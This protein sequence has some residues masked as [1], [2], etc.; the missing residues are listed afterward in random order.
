M[1]QEA[2]KKILADIERMAREAVA[3]ARV[4][5]SSSKDVLTEHQRA[6]VRQ[7]KESLANDENPYTELANRGQL[8]VGSDV[9]DRQPI[10]REVSQA[11]V[12]ELEAKW[13]KKFDKA[14]EEVYIDLD[15]GAT[16]RDPTKLYC[17]FC[18]KEVEQID[19]T[20]GKGPLRKSVKDY[21]L[22]L[23]D[24]NKIWEEKMI[25]FSDKLVACPTHCLLI[26]KVDL[27]KVETD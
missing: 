22:S 1:D 16:E 6:R 24:G 14:D 3:S 20:Y 2:R 8:G 10:V 18:G 17:S 26:K 19:A 12:S 4:Q 13:S 5:P 25:H 7:I 11:R 27:N 9:K 21:I 23:P 15:L